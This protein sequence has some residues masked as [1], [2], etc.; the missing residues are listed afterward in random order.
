MLIAP[1]TAWQMV[2]LLLRVLIG[3][4]IA[5][6]RRDKLQAVEDLQRVGIIDDVHALAHII[7]GDA[8]VVLEERRFSVNLG[9]N[10]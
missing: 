2:C 10:K 1:M 5:L 7:L 4:V 8:V 3:S 9:G 6:V